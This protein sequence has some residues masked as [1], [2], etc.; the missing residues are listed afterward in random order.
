LCVSGYEGTNLYLWGKN[1]YYKDFV[2]AHE[3][4]STTPLEAD[5][6]VFLWRNT[7]DQC[8]SFITFSDAD[9]TPNDLDQLSVRTTGVTTQA[10]CNQC[11]L[12]GPQYC[13]SWRVLN[14]SS[15]TP[16]V[17]DI[18]AN[19]VCTADNW[20]VNDTLSAPYQQPIEFCMHQTDQY[21]A[22]FNGIYWEL[23]ALDSRGNPYYY[24]QAKN[25]YLAQLYDHSESQWYWVQFQAPLP[26]AYTQSIAYC[27]ISTHPTQSL[28]DCAPWHY[29]DSQQQQYLLY[30][31]A[32]ITIVVL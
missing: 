6:R 13:T 3:Y 1:T 21:N 17:L 30:N 28:L 12:S 23:F 8:Y 22:Q 32:K 19:A 14:P 4:Y 29:L 26:V 11:A 24:V 5:R 18:T 25:Q 15:T 27:A 2:S 10:I 16:A 9:N 31:V 7:S 20:F